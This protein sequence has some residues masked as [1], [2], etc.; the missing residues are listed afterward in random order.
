L[1]HRVERAVVELDA[2]V[3]MTLSHDG[4]DLVGVHGSLAQQRQHGQSQW[5]GDLSFVRHRISCTKYMYSNICCQVNTAARIS[6]HD[7]LGRGPSMQC[8]PISRDAA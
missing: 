7:D 1:D 3:Q 8:S 5:I 2:L 4:S 6:V